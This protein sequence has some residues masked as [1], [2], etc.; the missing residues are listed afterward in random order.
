MNKNFIFAGS[1][2][3]G[4]LSVGIMLANIYI[5]DDKNVTYCSSYGAEMRGGAVNCEINV[6]DE[7]VLCVQNEQADYIITFNQTSYDKFIQKVKPNGTVIA[8]SSLIEQTK[9]RDDINY[10]FAP[11][12]ESAQKIGNIKVANSIALGILIRLCNNISTDI[13]TEK[14]KDILKNKKDLIQNNIDAFMFGYNYTI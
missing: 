9:P 12:T 8:N 13:I 14:Y 4:V 2:G 5:L 11:M 1:G 7:E 10:I 6:S 3:Q